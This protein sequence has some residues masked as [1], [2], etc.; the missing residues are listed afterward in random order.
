VEL[1]IHSLIRL[2]VVGLNIRT[3]LTLRTGNTYLLTYLLTYSVVK[4]K[5]G[6]GKVVP[7]LN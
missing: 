4:G 2:H 6:K 1:L 5:E 3:A 7:V